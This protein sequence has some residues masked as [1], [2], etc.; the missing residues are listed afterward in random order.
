MTRCGVAALAALVLTTGVWAQSALTIETAMSQLG[1]FDYNVRTAASGFIRRLSPDE[2]RPVLAQTVATHED[3]YVRYR[4]LVL[5]VGFGGSEARD[6][7]LE[8][9]HTFQ[10]RFGPVSLQLSRGLRR[11]HKYAR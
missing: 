5:L 6:T 3:G 11:L 7:V 4:A 2:A 9:G 10:R 1:D 8:I